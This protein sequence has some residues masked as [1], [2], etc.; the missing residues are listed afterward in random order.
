MYCQ[1]YS[2]EEQGLIDQLTNCWDAWMEGVDK[3]NPEI[4][5]EKCP[6]KS[7]ASMWWTNEGAPQQMDWARRN[8]A[9]CVLAIA[10]IKRSLPQ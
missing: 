5:Y 6:A 8:V 9:T 10:R 4:W 7:D 1:T 2:Q 3:N